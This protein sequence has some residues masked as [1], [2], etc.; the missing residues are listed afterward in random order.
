ME[1]AEEYLCFLDLEISI[2][3]NKFVT[4]IFSKPTDSHLYL[5]PTS[6]HSPKSVADILKDVVLKIRQICSSESKFS[7]KLEEYMAYL[8]STCHVPVAFTKMGKKTRSE[9]RRKLQ[10]TLNRKPITF[11]AK[12]NP[13]GPSVKAVIYKKYEHMLHN[14]ESKISVN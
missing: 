14:N 8:I 11:P 10:Q 9:T 13:R 2:L 12:Y 3:D 7:E 5:Q 6:Y 1:T 4:T